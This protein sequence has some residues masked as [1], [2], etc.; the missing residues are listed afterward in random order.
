MDPRS[1]VEPASQALSEP[2]CLAHGMDACGAAL[3]CAAFD[4]RTQ[5]TCYPERSRLDRQSCF[6]DRHCASGSCNVE[7]G[8]CRS[9]P[10]AAC[11]AAI[12]CATDPA[13]GR[14]ACVVESGT[15]QRVG[16]GSFGAVCA[17]AADCNEGL[18]CADG[19][20]IFDGES[21]GEITGEGP[22]FS[23][24]DDDWCLECRATSMECWFVC[25]GE[26]A[27]LVACGDEAGCVDGQALDL[28]CLVDACDAEL[29]AVER[30]AQREADQCFALSC[31]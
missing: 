2:C 22:C 26:Y 10:G 11:D 19:L 31:Y 8:A 6:E 24:P 4:G 7:A 17:G 3:F 16:D 18:A 21:C 15:C 14:F 25:T 13:G 30:C 28:R 27:A 20:C 12:G 29:C 1:C 5:P 9:M 23:A